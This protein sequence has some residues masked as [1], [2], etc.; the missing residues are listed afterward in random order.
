MRETDKYRFLNS[1]ISQVDLLGDTDET[2]AHQFSA[3]QKQTE[4]IRHILPRQTAAASTHLHL[5]LCIWQMLLSKV[6]Y[7]SFKVNIYILSVLSPC[8][9]STHYLPSGR[10]WF[11]QHSLPLE[12]GQFLNDI[13]SLTECVKRNSV[14]DSFC[15]SLTPQ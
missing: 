14:I 8:V 2:F 11:P 4:M 1:P 13:Y 3:A 6:T 7:I 9:Y 10:M 15:I 5:H 12:W